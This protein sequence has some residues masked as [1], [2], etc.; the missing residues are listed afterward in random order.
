[1]SAKEL[2]PVSF[3]LHEGRYIASVPM[4]QFFSWAG[5]DLERVLKE[6][7]QLYE[8][9]LSEMVTV[10]VDIDAVRAERRLLPARTVWRLGDLVFRLVE[11]LGRLSLQLDGVYEHLV[12]DLR[13]KRKWLEK[14]IILRRYLPREDAIPESL[15]WGR[16]EKGTRRVAEN[17]LKEKEPD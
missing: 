16:F 8:E 3:R 6:A 7:T 14:V 10:V 13:V 9:T 4:D 2:I 17:L 5:E 12:R 11:G 1:M 15:N